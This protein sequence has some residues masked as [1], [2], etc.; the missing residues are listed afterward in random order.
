MDGSLLRYTVGHCEK[1]YVESF[2]EML[3]SELLNREILTMLYYSR[4]NL[5][6]NRRREYDE[7]SDL[8]L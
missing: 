6:E 7:D 4:Q 8:V 1:G 2:N 3:R 5:I